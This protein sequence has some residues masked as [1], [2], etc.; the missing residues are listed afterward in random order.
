LFAQTNNLV[1]FLNLGVLLVNR[2]LGVTDNVEKEDMRDLKLD[3]FLNF[4]SHL[5][6]RGDARRIDALK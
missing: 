4:G 5:G 1:Q 3:L 2:E 6:S